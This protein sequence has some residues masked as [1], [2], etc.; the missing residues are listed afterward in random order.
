MCYYYKVVNIGAWVLAHFK[1]DAH[2]ERLE[3]CRR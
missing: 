1:T 3:C 2:M